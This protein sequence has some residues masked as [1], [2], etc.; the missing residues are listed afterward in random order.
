MVRVRAVPRDGDHNN[1]VRRGL[2]YGR[3]EGVPKN[4]DRARQ[5]LQQACGGG[6]AYACAMLKR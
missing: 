4:P 1:I 2:L 5:L 3:G 6:E